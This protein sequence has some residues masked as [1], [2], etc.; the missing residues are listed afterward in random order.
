MVRARQ[1]GVSEFDRVLGGGLI[2]GGVVLVAGEPGVGKSTLLLDVAANVAANRGPVLYVTGEESAAQVRLR[3]DRIGAVATDLLLAAQTDLGVVL[4]LIEEID[5]VL[6]VLDSVQTIASS[7]V[8][9]PSGGVTQ[10]REVAAALIAAAKTRNMPVLLVG[11]VTKDGAVAGP[12]TLEHLV[13]VV[14]T[15]EGDRHSVLR[16]VRATK[17]RYG[18]T[19][20][21][22]CFEL[23]ESGIR[24]LPDPS[25]LFLTHTGQ[26]VPGT[27]VTVTLEGRRALAAEVQGLVAPT[28]LANP[29]RTTSGLDS[30]RL[31]MVLAVLARRTRL[32]VLDVD[33]YASSVGGVRLTEPACDLAVA[34]AIA[35]AVIDLPLPVGTVAIGEV[36][37]AGE[38]RSVVGLPRRLSEAARLGFVRA[39]VPI[40][41][42]GPIPNGLTVVEVDTVAQALN[43]CGLTPTL[44]PL[45]G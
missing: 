42:C 9:G 36:G 11:H 6:L 35:S 3:A 21:V 25:G 44:D 17:N 40:G 29:R 10:V 16:L 41:T 30:A 12:R 33:V 26:L 28:A 24:G 20:E 31:A 22:G 27:A 14:V 34:L 5:P 32:P 4:G 2:P 37:L 19:D 7:E 1:T 39:L 45:S 13:D 15:F 38:I 8:D 18:P 43:E 23:T